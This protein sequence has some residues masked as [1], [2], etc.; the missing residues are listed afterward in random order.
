[1]FR[2]YHTYEY[3]IWANKKDAATIRAAYFYILTSP[4]LVETGFTQRTAI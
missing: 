4:V 3:V 1:M 2:L